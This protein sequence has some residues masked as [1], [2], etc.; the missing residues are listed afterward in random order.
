[1][2]REGKLDSES[3]SPAWLRFKFY[4][5]VVQL[6]KSEGVRKPDARSAGTRRVKE[7]EDF[8]PLVEWDADTRVRHGNYT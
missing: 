3:G 5:T 4:L 8:L 7:L 6:Y 2:T 1:M